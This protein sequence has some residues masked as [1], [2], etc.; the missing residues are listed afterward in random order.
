M[1]SAGAQPQ[2]SLKGWPRV[3]PA[4]PVSAQPCRFRPSPASLDPALRVSGRQVSGQ[5]RRCQPRPAGLMRV[6]L[7]PAFPAVPQL[8]CPHPCRKE[9]PKL[10]AVAE[11]VIDAA[12]NTLGTGATRRAALGG[13]ERVLHHRS[14]MIRRHSWTWRA[15]EKDQQQLELG[16][17]PEICSVR[18]KAELGDT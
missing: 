16:A 17:D 15:R 1:G 12:H 18:R 2:T 5:P 7:V 9:S 4:L 6:L 10:P 13:G 8:V 11:G 14:E 3:G